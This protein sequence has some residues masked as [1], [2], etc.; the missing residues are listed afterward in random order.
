M[1]VERILTESEINTIFLKSL[2]ESAEDFLGKQITGTV[3]SSPSTFTDIQKDALERAASDAG[4]KVLQLLDEASVVAA[5]TITPE[6][7]AE[8]LRQDRTQL[9]IDLG[10][11][12]L[13]R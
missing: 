5:T 10:N 1:L 3:V 11:P 6:W 4:V 9:L 13:S 2:I 12:P 8:N 7:S